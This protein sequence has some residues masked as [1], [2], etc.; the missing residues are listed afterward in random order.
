[1]E[2]RVP[3]VG[4]KLDPASGSENVLHGGFRAKHQEINHV[5][6][7]AFFVADA[8]RDLGEEIVIDAGKR[9][10]L[11]GDDARVATYGRVHLDAHGIVAVAGV[12]G[13]LI[14]ADGKAARARGNNIAAGANDQ[15]L[16]RVFVS[17]APAESATPRFIKR[18]NAEKIPESAPEGV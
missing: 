12:V 7:V 5:A 15:R 1:M 17:P 16:S 10:D 8:A 2:N 9:V 6:G 3:D 14:D 13:G 4:V 18:Q 11:S